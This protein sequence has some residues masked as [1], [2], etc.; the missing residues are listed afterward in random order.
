MADYKN[1]FASVAAERLLQ[2]YST[3]GEACQYL[4]HRVHD[5]WLPDSARKQ[6]RRII[7]TIRVQ[8]HQRSERGWMRG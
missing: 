4:Q 1:D 3:S 2:K 5:A 8:I 7:K 6:L